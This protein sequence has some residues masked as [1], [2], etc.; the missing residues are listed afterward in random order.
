M[1]ATMQ[2]KAILVRLRALRGSS[3]PSRSLA[4]GAHARLD[5]ERLRPRRFIGLGGSRMRPSCRSSTFYMSSLFDGSRIGPAFDV[6]L[7][8]LMPLRPH[9]W[10]EVV[11]D[12]CARPRRGWAWLPKPPSQQTP[13]HAAPIP[14]LPLRTGRTRS[15]PRAFMLRG[16]RAGRV[17]LPAW[18]GMECHAMRDCGCCGARGALLCMEPREHEGVHAFWC[19]NCGR[20]PR[21]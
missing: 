3:C 12:F 6:C 20:D 5:S 1:P 13:P 15:A 14:R 9:R 16:T 11:R 10:V 7:D 8:I 2:G 19:R 17:T 21:C 18:Q 4:G